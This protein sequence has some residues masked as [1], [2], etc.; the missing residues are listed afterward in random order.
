MQI[1]L[2]GGSDFLGLS[3]SAAQW[4]FTSPG[5]TAVTISNSGELNLSDRNLALEVWKEIC[6]LRGH[7]AAFLPPYR[8]LRHKERPSGRIGATMPNARPTAARHGKYAYCRRLDD[9]KL[10]LFN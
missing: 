4:L 1:S 9:E 5:L 8:V 10:A 7:A 3:G 6:A 2:P